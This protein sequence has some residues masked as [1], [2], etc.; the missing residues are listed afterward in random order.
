MK[1]TP[2]ASDLQELERVLMHCKATCTSSSL[3]V[4][5]NFSQ[6]VLR[7]NTHQP[8]G[9]VWVERQ[10]FDVTMQLNK[11][12]HGCQL[13]SRAVQ[14]GA[15]YFKTQHIASLG[16]VCAREWTRFTL[17]RYNT[18][19]RLRPF[20]YGYFLIHF[21]KSSSIHVT[22]NEVFR[23][24]LR[25]WCSFISTLKGKNIHTFLKMLTS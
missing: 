24:P 13:L 15:K 23:K 25:R 2:V 21:L 5:F 18:N 6:N 14:S 7:G 22:G 8:I 10:S 4:E 12:N 20:V 16:S 19:M 3:G 11:T 1:N 9:D 17:R